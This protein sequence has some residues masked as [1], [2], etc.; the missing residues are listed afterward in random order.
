MPYITTASV[1]RDMITFIDRYA[2]WRGGSTSKPSRRNSQ[3]EK[4]QYWGFSYG[5]FLGMTFSSMFP[6]RTSRIIVDGVVDIDDYIHA[7]WTD[8]LLDSEKTVDWFYSSCARAG[9]KACSLAKPGSTAADVRT[10][11]ESILD[12][13][14]R[15]PVVSTGELP[16]LIRWSDVKG[17]ITSY[18]YSPNEYPQ[19]ADLLIALEGVQSSSVAASLSKS[20]YPMCGHVPPPQTNDAAQVG[21]A[22]GDAFTKQYAD[23]TLE[24]AQAHYERLYKLSP[25]VAGAWTHYQ[26]NCAAWKGHAKHSFRGPFGGSAESGLA[27][28]LFIGNTADPVTPIEGA[29]N[30]SER[31]SGARLLTQNTPGHTSFAMASTCTMRKVRAY[32]QTG[33][34]PKKRVVCQPNEKVFEVYEGSSSEEQSADALNDPTVSVEDEDAALIAAHRSIRRFFAEKRFGLGQGWGLV[35]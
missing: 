8:N 28:M 35:S 18:L 23:Y 14:Y 4:L 24:D 31:F 9:P 32:I 26:L 1:A 21:I 30:M 16:D 33:K 12:Q 29:Q 27:P 5:S 7:R 13:L 6:E 15:H 17:L 10:R 20:D 11:A 22:C 3:P 19:I 25:T 34:L 2:E